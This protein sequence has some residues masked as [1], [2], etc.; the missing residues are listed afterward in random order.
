M[1][2]MYSLSRRPSLSAE[3]AARLREQ[4]AGGR[5]APG[6]QLP[7]ELVLSKRFGVS[8]ATIREVISILRAQGLITTRQG[9]GA[10]VA[11]GLAGRPFQI[12][13]RDVR[14]VDDMLRVVEL[15]TSV[16]VDAAGLAAQRRQPQDLARMGALLDKIDDAIKRSESAADHDFEFHCAI[17]DA[18][19]NA[20]FRRFLESLG[21]VLIPRQNMS[22]G[23]LRPGADPRVYLRRI[24]AEHRALY[25]A[26]EAGDAAAARKAAR[27]HLA[28]G[29]ERYR[30]HGDEIEFPAVTDRK[31]ANSAKT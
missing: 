7:T 4:I 25:A 29:R 8:R 28:R 26:I 9:L 13:P 23:L 18:T 12:D 19:G 5:L 20:Y 30:E 3:I 2:A 16:E 10:F 22:Q 15:R 14:S 6:A 27:A 21:A 17:A 31:T 11:E 24:Q 1:D